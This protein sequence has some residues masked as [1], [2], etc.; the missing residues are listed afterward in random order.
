MYDHVPSLRSEQDMSLCGNT[1]ENV[2][3]GDGVTAVFVTMDENVA[4]D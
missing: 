4:N 1:V 2:G 3:T